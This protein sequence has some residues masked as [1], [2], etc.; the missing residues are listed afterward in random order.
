MKDLARVRRVVLSQHPA[1]LAA[2]ALLFVALAAAAVPSARAAAQRLITGKDIQNGSISNADLRDGSVN[3]HKL[4]DGH[5][6][7]RDLSKGLRDQIARAA[8]GKDGATGP[9]G[10]A[11]KSVTAEVIPAGDPRCANGAGG[12]AYSLAG[13]TVSVCNGSDGQNATETTAALD[14]GVGDGWES[15][16]TAT[17]DANGW[18]HLTGYLTCAGP[19]GCEDQLLELPPSFQ[20]SPDKE[21]FQLQTEDQF[22]GAYDQVN[23]AVVVQADTV[24]VPDAHT[25]MLNSYRVWLSGITYK[26]SA[27]G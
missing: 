25:G 20:S 7:P 9:D 1:V 3:S 5:V 13:E 16:A 10:P 14:T 12:V 15:N 6:L 8:D 19:S 26:A 22:S 27:T 23:G 24:T 17:R 11:G 18:V 2:V 21:V 4:Q